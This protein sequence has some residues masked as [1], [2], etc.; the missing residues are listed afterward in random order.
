MIQFIY[1]ISIYI[2]IKQTPF[3]TTYRYHLEIYKTPIIWLDNLYTAIK[4]KHLKFLYNKFKNKLSFIKNQITKYYNIKKMKE[5]SFEKRDK[6]YLLYK[7]IITK[8]SNNKLNFKK[9]R[10]FI[11]IQ[12]I[13]KFNYKLSLLKTI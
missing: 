10:P 13:S 1:N 2:S 9:L 7:N 4:I 5:P 12:K 8:Q 11:I 6:T 3:F